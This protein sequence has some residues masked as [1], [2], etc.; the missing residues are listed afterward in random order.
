MKAFLHPFMVCPPK[1]TP[2]KRENH[3]HQTRKNGCYD[4]RD[5]PCRAH[6]EISQTQ[7]DKYQMLSLICVI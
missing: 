6:V 3:K 7:K 4:N 2:R 5:G 1:E